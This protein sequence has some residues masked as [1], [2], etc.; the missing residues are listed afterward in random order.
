MT[1]VTTSEHAPPA[2]DVQGL[3]GD[4]VVALTGLRG[5][6]ALMVL[7]TH[8]SFQTGYLFDGPGGL[9]LSRFD[10]GVA[11]FFA[12]SGYLLYRPW[13][14]SLLAGTARPRV[15]AYLVRRATRVLPPYWVV[16]FAVWAVSRPDGLRTVEDWVWQLLLLQNY[17]IN[18]FVLGLTQIWSLGTEV[19]FYLVL[20]LFA[21]VLGRIARDRAGAPRP[22]RLLTALAVL[23]AASLAWPAAY[24]AGPLD[25][26]VAPLWLPQ[27][28][29]W[30]AVGMVLALL[31]V[32]AL[33]TARPSRLLREAA[34]APWASWA[35]AAGVLWWSSTPVSGP[36]LLV[37]RT[38]AEEVVRVAMYGVVAGFLLLPLV[39]ARVHPDPAGSAPRGPGR[40]LSTPVMHHLG[41]ISYPVFLVQLL[42]LD[43][44]YRVLPVERFEG[45]PWVASLVAAVTATITIV[46]SEL[47]HRLVE[48]PAT[49]LGRRLTSGAPRAQPAPPP[50]PRG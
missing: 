10:V 28:I 1:H 12:L 33:H 50:A 14:L 37:E 16:V 41:R 8:V 30:F 49:R 27:L 19:A 35:I 18:R 31:E 40:L 2:P 47:L 48:L 23:S 4:E 46:S 9:V 29:S 36:Y 38:F 32:A 20:P 3:R 44:A 15:G 22:G 45:G 42:A 5:V 17:E 34:A 43:L 26:F 6:A 24:L 39:A 21:V 13:A 25:Q 11:V 7:G